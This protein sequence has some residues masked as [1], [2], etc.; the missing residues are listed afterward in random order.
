MCR[1]ADAT[2]PSDSALPE[3]SPTPPKPDGDAGE[4]QPL[5]PELRIGL[6]LRMVPGS[7]V[8]YMQITPPLMQDTPYGQDK[9]VLT[10]LLQRHGVAVRG[11]MGGAIVLLQKLM[12]RVTRRFDRNCLQ[13]IS[14]RAHARCTQ[15]WKRMPAP[16]GDPNFKLEPFEEGHDMTP[17]QY[18][19]DIETLWERRRVEWLARPEYQFLAENLQKGNDT[20]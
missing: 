12:V 17:E 10:R 5:H 4:D 20:T 3:S 2:P 19:A 1:A 7:T 9:A 11:G 6:K 13:C 16:P 14:C 8:V 18:M 15:E